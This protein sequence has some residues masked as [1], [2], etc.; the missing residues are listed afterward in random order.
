MQP[1]HGRREGLLRHAGQLRGTP[2]QFTAHGV[3]VR[4]GLPALAVGG[5]DGGRELVQDPAQ[6]GVGR[7]L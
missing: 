7:H 6:L 5:L 4:G 3:P 2:L 1:R